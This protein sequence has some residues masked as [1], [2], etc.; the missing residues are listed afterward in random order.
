MN[1]EA[2]KFAE[3]S[4]EDKMTVVKQS[5]LSETDSYDGFLIRNNTYYLIM[6]YDPFPYY[7][8]F[9]GY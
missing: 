1:Y 2:L 4:I 8:Y 7:G 5:I 9:S 6:Q 3:L